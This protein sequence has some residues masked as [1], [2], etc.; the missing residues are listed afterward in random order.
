MQASVC[1]RFIIRLVYADTR[2]ESSQCNVTSP[3]SSHTQG[4]CS[5]VYRHE[6]LLAKLLLLKLLLF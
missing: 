1:A 4:L 5:A 2:S 6:R 3:A